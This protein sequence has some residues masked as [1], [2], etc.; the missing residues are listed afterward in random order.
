MWEIGPNG[1]LGRRW[2]TSNRWDKGKG[3]DDNEI[4]MDLLENKFSNG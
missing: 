2:P 4:T 3:D 1:G